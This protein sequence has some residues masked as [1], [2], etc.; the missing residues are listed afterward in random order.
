M[1]FNVPFQNGHVS[2]TSSRKL[3]ETEALKLEL[4]E[5]EMGKLRILRK[6]YKDE[7]EEE[8]RI[9]SEERNR[10]EQALVHQQM[11]SLMEQKSQE[12]VEESVH[13]NKMKA[14]VTCM[15]EA[16]AATPRDPLTEATIRVLSVYQG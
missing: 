2:D 1:C 9:A 5:L 13:R 15:R 10:Q 3:V 16:L 12:D 4:F 6:T 8:E 7:K 11:K 14:A